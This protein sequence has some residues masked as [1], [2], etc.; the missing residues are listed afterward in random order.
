[1]IGAPI[2]PVSLGSQARQEKQPS[3]TRGEGAAAVPA[4]VGPAPLVPGGLCGHPIAN[5]FPLIEGVEFDELVADI[6]ANGI[7]EE[8]VILEGQILDGRNRYRAGVAAGVF[9]AEVNPREDWNFVHFGEEGISGAFGGDPVTFVISKNL[10]RRHL[11]ESQRS[12]IAATLATMPRGSRTDIAPIGAKSDAEAARLLNVGERSV[13]RAKAVRRDGAPELADAV[14]RGEVSV[15]AAAELVK[16]LPLEQQRALVLEVAKS[17]D[18][19]RAF[20]GAVKELRREKQDEKRDRREERERVLGERQRALPD[21]RYGVILADPEWRFEPWSRATG[22]DRAA[23]NHYPTSAAEVIASRPVEA[24]ADRDA[25]LFLWA[26]V[27]MLPQALMVMGAWGFDY[28]SHVVWEK[29]RL[30]TGYWFRNTHELLLVGTRGDVPAPALGRQW[31]S[32]VESPPGG[33]SAK[34]AWQY[35][36]IEAYFPGLTKIELNAR[37]GRPGWD[38]WGNEAPDPGAALL[39]DD[40]RAAL[41]AAGGA[42]KWWFQLWRPDV[43]VTEQIKKDR[44]AVAVETGLP[45]YEGAPEAVA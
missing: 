43:Y 16:A 14:T 31:A 13:E 34:P 25:V 36:L 22:M 9:P 27:P 40:Q 20:A 7:A 21:K 41:A 6:A 37:S 30:G 18:T 1:M 4:I 15:S 8:I 5:A 38:P 12:M 17:D 29:D 33:H 44:D 10:H 26:T 28:V 3:P 2:D 19:R 23:D 42:L 35:E 32:S 39:S 24:I 45:V 11:D